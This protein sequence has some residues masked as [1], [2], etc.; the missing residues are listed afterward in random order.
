MKYED[1]YIMR[2]NRE[3]TRMLIRLLF[4][5]EAGSPL[6]ELALDEIQRANLAEWS[7]R[8]DNGDINGAE[9]ELS[10]LLEDGGLEN[11]QTGVLF[12]SYLNEKE[13]AFLESH[14]Y[15]REEI[16]MGLEE[17][18]ESCGLEDITKLF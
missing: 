15:S 3:I 4:H 17:L 14:D 8:I 1:D 2:I 7:R 16:Q 5:V 11:I 10:E 9:N 13:D 18:A 12:Y 6:T